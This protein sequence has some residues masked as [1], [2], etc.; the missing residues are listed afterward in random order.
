M[1]AH[2]TKSEL[3]RL[4]NEIEIEFV[5]D[6]LLKIPIKKHEGITRFLCPRCGEF[7]TGVNRHTNLARCF[8]CEENFNPIDLVMVQK[9]IGFIETVRLLKKVYQERYQPTERSCR[10]N[11]QSARPGSAILPVRDI[12]AGIQLG[13]R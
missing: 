13:T 4:R 7:Q 9:K 3:Y 10:S 8:R 1:A 2:F 11:E 12:L 5:I 6:S